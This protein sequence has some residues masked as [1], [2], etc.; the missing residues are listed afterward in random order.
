[1]ASSVTT[2]NESNPNRHATRRVTMKSSPMPVVPDPDA[3]KRI[4]MT[5]SSHTRLAKKKGSSSGTQSVDVTAESQRNTDYDSN[6]STD[7]KAASSSGPAFA[8][9]TQE[10]ID[11]SHETDRQTQLQSKESHG[12]REKILASCAMRLWRTDALRASN[13]TL[14]CSAGPDWHGSKQMRRRSWTC[15]STAP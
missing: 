2:G 7:M 4:S 15:P 12:K 9:T 5:S 10:G 11:G 6:R 8:V 1:M 13:G 3:R 14:Q